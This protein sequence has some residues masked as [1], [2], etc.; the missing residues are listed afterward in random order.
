MGMIDYVSKSFHDLLAG[1]LDVISNSGSS[2]GSH[3]P[4]QECFMVGVLEGRVED[5]HSGKLLRAALMM[6]QGEEP[7][8]TTGTAQAAA[9]AAEGAR[10][11]GPLDRTGACQTRARDQTLWGWSASVRCGPR[12]KP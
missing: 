7:S 9:G 2:G 12:P 1:E 3:H 4:L 11:G 6:G 5:A 10:G 8:S